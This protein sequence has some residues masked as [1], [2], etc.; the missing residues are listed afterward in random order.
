MSSYH[1][2]MEFAPPPTPG[3]VRSVVL[4]VLAHTALLAGLATGVQWKHQAPATVTVE[5]ELWSALPQEAAPPPTPV[6]EP[7]LPPQPVPEE[8]TP[9]PPPEPVQQQSEPVP[10]P[11]IAIAREKLRLENEKE[12]QVQQEKLAL[13]KIKLAQAEKENEKRQQEKLQAEKLQKD[14][15]AREKLARDK[16]A[17]DK[18][19][20]QAAAEAKAAE[21]KAAAAE[22]KKIADLRQQN[23]QRMAGL[24]AGS[25]SPGATGSAAQAS[26]PSAGYG[27]RIRARIKPNITYTESSA[28]NPT[29][30]VEVRTSPDGTIISRKLTHSS[31]VKAW[32]DAVLNAIDKTEV[33]PKDVDGRVP[34]SLI[35]SFRPKD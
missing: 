23:L 2:K 30:E 4:A 18:K 20:Q 25:G 21:A 34:T 27:S 8:K 19:Q 31:G 11:A 22:A 13:E 12:R 6:P 5:A 28:D 26:G 9:P 35:I 3:L 7:A 29:A 14:K 33:L 16:S 17:A 1:A 24:A 15:E 10:D 32:D